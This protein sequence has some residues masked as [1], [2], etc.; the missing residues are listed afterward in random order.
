M[1]VVV[2]VSCIV[3]CCVG[4]DKMLCF[5][6]VQVTVAVFA[7][8]VC[9][10]CGKMLCFCA[11]VFD[12]CTVFCCIFVFVV[13]VFASCVANC[14]VGSGKMLCFFPVAVVVFV[15]CICTRDMQDVLHM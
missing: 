3:G 11:N 15:S 12:L 9:I 1:F 6:C 4:N 7:A 2:I 8:C 14:C 13:A 5:F 10:R